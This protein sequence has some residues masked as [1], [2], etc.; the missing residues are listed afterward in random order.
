M[1]V[2]GKNTLYG[3]YLG[4]SKKIDYL[5]F[6]LCYYQAIEWAIENNYEFVEG[7]A[8]GPHKIQRGYLPE[9]TYSSHYIANENFRNAVKEFLNE[10]EKIINRDIQII[11]N[12]FTPFKKN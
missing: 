11:N 9:K 1:H 5:H 2:I 3:R 6:E 4:S 10:E 8:Q 7:G 12:K